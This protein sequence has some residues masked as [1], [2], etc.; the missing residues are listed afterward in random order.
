M[1]Y[2]LGHS[3]SKRINQIK[4]NFQCAKRIH[5]YNLNYQY[6]LSYIRMFLQSII[7]TVF[8]S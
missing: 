2:S 3:D 6:V 5:Y 8:N 1:E 4:K 7:K